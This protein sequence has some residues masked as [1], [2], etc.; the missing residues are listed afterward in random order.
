MDSKKSIKCYNCGKVGHY[1]NN[2]PNPREDKC[3][4]CGQI[5][6]VSFTCPKKVHSVSQSLP[7]DNPPPNAMAPVPSGAPVPPNAISSSIPIGLCYSCGE[8]G[9]KSKDC[10]NKQISN[11]S[12]NNNIKCF[13][14]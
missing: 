10:S 8:S 9:H 3:F 13:K 5:G 6:H 12:N 1:S 4:N 14:Y 7:I 2:C 11:N